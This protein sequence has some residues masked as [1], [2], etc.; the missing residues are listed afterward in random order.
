[1]SIGKIAHTYVEICVC[2]GV[3]SSDTCIIRIPV[4]QAYAKFFASYFTSTSF[5][6]QTRFSRPF[7]AIRRPSL[8][9]SLGGPVGLNNSASPGDKSTPS[10]RHVGEGVLDDDSIE[11]Q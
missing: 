5:I 9:V 2:I 8:T 10:L 11:W 7:S 3:A 1:M 4:A 6:F